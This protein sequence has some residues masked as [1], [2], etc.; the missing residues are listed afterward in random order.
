MLCEHENPNTMFYSAHKSLGKACSCSDEWIE[1]GELQEVKI[2]TA[3]LAQMGSLWFSR[4]HYHMRLK[5]Q[6]IAE[7]T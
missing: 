3:L 1:T 7:V 4:R 5:R 2:L 6:A